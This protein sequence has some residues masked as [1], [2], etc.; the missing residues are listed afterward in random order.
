MSIKT[1]TVDEDEIIFEEALDTLM[2]KG[3]EFL[4]ACK[5]KFTDEVAKVKTYI[6]CIRQL[7]N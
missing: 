1:P 7:F 5:V 2:F 6:R 4:V 3:Y